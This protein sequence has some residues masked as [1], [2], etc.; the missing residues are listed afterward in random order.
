MMPS[1]LYPFITGKTEAHDQGLKVP[2]P[3]KQAAKNVTKVS[4]FH[5]MMGP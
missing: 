2:F 3:R 4:R 5:Q 1:R